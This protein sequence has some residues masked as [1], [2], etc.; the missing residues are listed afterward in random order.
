MTHPQPMQEE[1]RCRGN[2]H[3]QQSHCNICGFGAAEQS[4]R[5]ER[6]R[7]EAGLVG[8][9]TLEYCLRRLKRCTILTDGPTAP[10]QLETDSLSLLNTETLP[11]YT[12]ASYREPHT[13]R[14]TH[15]LKAHRVASSLNSHVHTHARTQTHFWSSSPSFTMQTRAEGMRKRERGVREGGRGGEGDSA[16]S[17]TTQICSGAP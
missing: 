12:A 4:R 15:T 7:R 13:L 6:K 16:A 11:K 3:Q 9:L 17:P 10:V 5:P 8:S 1:R 2:L 14:H